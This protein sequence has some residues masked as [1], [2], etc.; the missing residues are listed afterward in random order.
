MNQAVLR[1]WGCDG[2]F[3]PI[4]QDLLPCA[5][6][7]LGSS[8]GELSCQPQLWLK[9]D[10]GQRDVTLGAK[11]IRCIRTQRSVRRRL[12]LAARAARREC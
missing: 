11:S 1:C 12:C 10:A 7:K 8:Q 4:S 2:L 3:L 5:L 6:T 9:S